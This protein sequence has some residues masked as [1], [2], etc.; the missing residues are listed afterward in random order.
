MGK[1][2]RSRFE[3]DYSER[4][5]IKNNRQFIHQ[6]NVQ[7]AL[8]VCDDLDGLGDLDAGDLV[9]A[10]INVDSVEC[11][12]LLCGPK[13][14]IYAPHPRGWVPQQSEKPALAGRR[15]SVVHS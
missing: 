14:G 11:R 5:E 10:R 12:N 3:R 1:Y 9:D 2:I 8:G 4:L 15:G 6:C 13:S 7:V